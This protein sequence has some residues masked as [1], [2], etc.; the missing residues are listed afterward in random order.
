MLLKIFRLIFAFVGFRSICTAQYNMYDE[1]CLD[2]YVTNDLS[3]TILQVAP[4][5]HQIVPF[6]RRDQFEQ[7]EFSVANGTPSATLVDL[8]KKNTTIEQLYSWSAQLDLIEEYEAYRKDP[9]RESQSIFYNCSSQSKFGRFCQYSFHSQ[10]N[11]KHRP[12]SF[13]R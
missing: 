9:T 5:Q 13:S 12:S 4:E 3:I 11:T 10:V 7:G 2:Y 1:D 6:C 8:H